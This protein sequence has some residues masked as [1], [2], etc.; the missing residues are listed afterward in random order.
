M[1]FEAA[2]AVAE[3]D[4]IVGASLYRS[5][6]VS[7]LDT[8]P[9]ILDESVL[10]AGIEKYCKLFDGREIELT[11]EDVATIVRITS[12][13]MILHKYFVFTENIAKAKQF[14]CKKV[15]VLLLG[16]K[17]N[18]NI[19]ANDSVRNRKGGDM[20]RLAYEICHRE[21]MWSLPEIGSGAEL[22]FR[23][24]GL[25]FASKRLLPTERDLEF[26]SSVKDNEDHRIHH[27]AYA[28][29]ILARIHAISENTI[30]VDEECRRTIALCDQMTVA[31]KSVSLDQEKTVEEIFW[32]AGGYLEDVATLQSGGTLVC[33][34]F[35][36]STLSPTTKKQLIADF[37]KMTMR[38]NQDSLEK[39]FANAAAAAVRGDYNPDEIDWNDFGNRIQDF[40]DLFDNREK[41]MTTAELTFCTQLDA[42][43]APS[44]LTLLLF[45]HHLAMRN[46]ERA[47]F[48]HKRCGENPAGVDILLFNDIAREHIRSNNPILEREGANMLRSVYEVCEREKFWSDPRFANTG[49]KCFTLFGYLCYANFV[50]GKPP[51]LSA[52]KGD[53]DFLSSVKQNKKALIHHRAYA[54]YTLAQIHA[55]KNSTTLMSKEC[56][57]T[58]SLCN[59]MTAAEKSRVVNDVTVQDLFWGPAGYLYNIHNLQSKG[60][61]F[62]F[63]TVVEVESPTDTPQ[64]IAA[65]KKI[66][67]NHLEK[68]GNPIRKAMFA[69]CDAEAGMR[70]DPI[71]QALSKRVRMADG[72]TCDSCGLVAVATDSIPPL[73]MKSCSKCRRRWYCSEGGHKAVC[74][75]ALVLEPLDIVRIEGWFDDDAEN[76]VV[77]ESSLN[78]NIVELQGIS[79]FAD[80]ELDVEW[81][82]GFIGGGV[83]ARFLIRIM[84]KEERPDI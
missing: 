16:P 44:N 45:N 5:A 57:R 35:E 81:K 41:E 46:T 4:R 84:V 38:K 56:R 21:N 60:A 71:Y 63:S 12:V 30:L 75:D 15:E 68:S 27:R 1:G 76:G 6:I 34:Q 59:E 36:N 49:E 10:D 52:L 28:A 83:K 77:S 65:R 72:T 62:G 8:D 66:I 19:N 50:P 23:R 18:E 2:E 26:L 53:L 67:E 31:E 24:Y 82:C 22:A 11:G 43:G 70:L 20:L 29:F 78:G 79:K 33:H 39:Q 80:N 73:V 58:I 55:L 7:G 37:L 25:V 40:C 69:P 42:S 32:G 47:K 54:A 14:H 17:G 3:G 9:D 64:N 51:F 48:Y 74:R 61:W 13:T